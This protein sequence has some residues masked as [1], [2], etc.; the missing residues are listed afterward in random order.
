[1][2]K[3][4]TGLLFLLVAYCANAQDHTRKLTGVVKEEGKSTGISSVTVSIKGKAQGAVTTDAN[5]QFF[6][7]VPEGRVILEFTSVGYATKDVIVEEGGSTV[8]AFLAVESR[9]L[10]S[11]VVT[12]LG[13]KR[14]EKSVTYATQQ[15]SN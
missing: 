2:R 4:L 10:N 5:G 15:I 6:I 12:A 7:T 13:V 11:V 1:M 3:V 9:E 8:D 14:S